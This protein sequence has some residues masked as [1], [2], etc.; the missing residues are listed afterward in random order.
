MKSTVEQ[1]GFLNPDELALATVVE[2]PQ[3]AIDLIL[4]YQQRVGPPED[5]PKAF[6]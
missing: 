5:V 2:E 1:S 3:E 6:A 4:D